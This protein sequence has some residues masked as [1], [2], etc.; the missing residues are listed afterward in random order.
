MKEEKQCLG[1]DWRGF[2]WAIVAVGGGAG[3]AD[4]CP[5][6]KIESGAKQP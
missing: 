5:S 6:L 4:F 3:N 1:E 2:F